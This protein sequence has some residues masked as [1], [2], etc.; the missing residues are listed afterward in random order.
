MSAFFITGTDTEIGKT[1][2]TA[3]LT[4]LGASLGLRSVTIK[5]LA[6]GQDFVDGRW[7][8]DDVRHLRAAS[9]VALTDQQV[10]PLQLRTPCAPHIAAQ[11]DG[12]RIERT[13]LLAAVQQTLALGDIGFVEGVGGFRVPLIDGWDTAD[14][15]VDLALPVIV[16]VG[17]RL[18]C[19]NHALLTAEA[20]RSRGLQMV[21]WV[22]NTVDPAMPY[23]EDNL[24]ALTAG[25]KAPCWGQVPRLQKPSPAAVAAHL[26]LDALRQAMETA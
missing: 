9:N 19:I 25:L 7:V 6:A 15:A 1:T 8:N 20:I 2:V 10:G 11:L 13:P 18:G 3:G 14:M 17:M 16:V 5:P 21:G 24:A 22:A 4:F 23:L 12:L 26:N